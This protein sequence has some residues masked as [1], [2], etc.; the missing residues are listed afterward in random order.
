VTPTLSAVALPSG[1]VQL[2]TNPV[3]GVL[4][5]FFVGGVAVGPPSAS[6]SVTVPNVPV[7]GTYTVTLV[8]PNGC[9]SAPSTPVLVTATAVASLNGVR[10]RVYPNPTTDGVLTLDLSGV[11]AKTAQLTVL[12][13]L[14]QVVHTGTVAAGTASLKL[15]QRAAGVYTFR[16]QTAE[17]VL[18]QRVVRQ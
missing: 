15:T 7:N 1:G 10:L 8:V 4:Y 3:G 13:A 9:T 18:T 11:N 2:S 12:N 5:Q 16:V 17:G 14:G 6:F